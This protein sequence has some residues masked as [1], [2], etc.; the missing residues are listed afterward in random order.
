MENT[1]DEG[2]QKFEKFMGG[3]Y[4]KFAIADLPPAI[5]NEAWWTMIQE[6][7]TPP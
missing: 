3:K 4:E 6:Y 1:N 7:V 5:V 2:G